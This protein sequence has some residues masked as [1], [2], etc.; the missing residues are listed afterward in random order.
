VK[1]EIEETVN[2]MVEKLRRRQNPDGSWSFCFENSLITYAYMIILIRSLFLKEDKLVYQLVSRLLNM[3]TDK[4]TWKVFEDEEE[5]NLS[6]TIEAYFALNPTG[7]GL[8]GKFYIHYHSYKWIWPF[9]TMSHYL[10]KYNG[11]RAQ[12]LSLH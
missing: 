2:K 12:A 1:R 8:K 7:A 9:L 5:G 4:G 10:N 11:G 3:Q 6:A